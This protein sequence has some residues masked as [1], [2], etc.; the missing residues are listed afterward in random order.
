MSKVTYSA[1]LY[2]EQHDDT[3]DNTYAVLGNDLK[4]KGMR[5]G[6]TILLYQLGLSSIPMQNGYI[7]VPTT[8]GSMNQL[9]WGRKRVNNE[10]E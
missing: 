1:A 5:I 6:L 10:W 2:K 4:D 3:Y 9:V 7:L 8:F